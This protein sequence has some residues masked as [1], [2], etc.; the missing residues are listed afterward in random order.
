MKKIYLAGG[1]FWGVQKYISLIPGV[2]KTTV[3]YANGTTE[4]PTYED[5]CARDTGHSEAVEIT[6]DEN[7]LPLT[8]LL[9]LYADVINPTSVNR[10]GADVGTQYRT[11]I[12][13]TDEADA[14]IIRG[15]LTLLGESLS[16]PV[17]IECEPI[18]QFY[19][20]E[21]YHQNYLDKNPNGY[22]HIPKSKFESAR[23]SGN[24]GVSV[25]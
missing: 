18:R 22:C 12:Y 16:K 19:P 20:A 2:V 15:W 5:V 23:R 25:S 10:Q 1:C 14:A 17:A 9:D 13:Y 7:A 4:A 21:E 6:Y 3:G 11:G 24:V 8:R